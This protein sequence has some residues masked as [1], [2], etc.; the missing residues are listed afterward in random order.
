MKS[1]DIVPLEEKYIPEVVEMEYE[2]WHDYYQQ[3]DI[4]NVI[5][6]TENKEEIEKN[7]REFISDSKDTKGPLIAG[8]LRKAY[9]ALIDGK[10]VGV[11]AV[12]SFKENTWPR[13]DRILKKEDGTIKKTAKFQNLYIHKDYRGNLIGHFLTLVRCDY[14]L[15]KG[16]EAIFMTTYSD[17]TKTNEYHKKNGM[18]HIYDYESLQTYEGGKKVS[19]S[20]FLNDNLQAYRDDAEIYINKKIAAG[21]EVKLGEVVY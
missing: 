1:I 15:E 7:W 9:I 19:I 10:V 21:C 2:A 3:Y 4:Y 20:C 12:T 5:K 11:G 16:Y 8:S 17:A 14:M 13:I 18:N 6:S